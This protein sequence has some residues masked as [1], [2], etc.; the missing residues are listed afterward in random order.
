MRLFVLILTLSFLFFNCKNKPQP[1]Q[2][3]KAEGELAK[4]FLEFYQKF[5]SDSTYQMAHIEWPLKGETGISQDTTSKRQ[6]TEWTPANWR[7]MHFP[8][9]T[10]STLK[11]SF[12]TVGDVMVIERMSYPMVGF[13]YE[14]Q[15]YKEE[16][17][18]WRLIYYA[19]S[20]LMQ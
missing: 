19:E 14:R 1:L 18:E 3:A 5:H 9:T 13:G 10:M 12:E 16:N 8:D 17:G 11:R 7:L 4:D 6:L 2:Q 15:F 20:T